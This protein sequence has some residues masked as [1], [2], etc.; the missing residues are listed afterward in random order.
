MCVPPGSGTRIAID[1]DEDSVLD[2]LDLCPAHA[3]PSQADGDAD[4][5]GSACDN[6]TLVANP[7][8]LD[9]DG[10]GFGNI[11]DADLNNSGATTAT[12]FN[13]LRSVL[14]QSAASSATAAAADLNGSGTVTATDFNLLRVRLNTVPGPSALR[15][16]Q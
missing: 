16:A 14:N 9:A 5:V 4:L 7:D 13:L 6:C 3:D 15:P 12:D 11:C 8:Q 10:D 1:R 2:G